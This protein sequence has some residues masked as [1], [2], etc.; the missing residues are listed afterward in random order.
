MKI[1]LTTLIVLS[2]IFNVYAQELDKVKS[3]EKGDAAPYKG[4]LFPV[5]M[6]PELRNTYLERNSYKLL[7]DSLQTSLTLSEDISKK[8]QDKVNIL[9]DQN[10]K[11]SKQLNETRTF[12]TLERITWFTLGIF[13]T[14]LAFYGASKLA[15]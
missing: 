11:I 15:K 2:N 3:V 5:E 10:D 8:N 13:A 1:F 7:N 4:L 14:G 12:S 9:L 6:I